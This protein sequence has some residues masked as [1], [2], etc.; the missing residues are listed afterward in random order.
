MLRYTVRRLL[1]TIPV[2]LLLV[3]L[4]FFMIRLAPGG[5][6][7]QERNV[8]PEV[9]RAL[10]SHY[11]LDKPLF[12]QYLDYLASLSKGDLGPSFRFANKTVNELIAD[13]FPVSFEL[14]CWALLVA[15]V[16]GLPV[17]ILAA[18]R[19]NTGLDY[20]PMSLAMVGICLPTFVMGPLLALVFGIHFDWL[21][22][23]GWFGWKDRILPALTLG[24]Y[25]AAYV[26]RL[27]RGGMLEV[28][29]QDFIRTAKAKGATGRRIVFKHALRGGM[30]PVIAFLG[31]AIAG[32]IAGSFVVETIFQVP[33]LGQ[34]FVKAATNRDY[35]MVMGTVLFFA[36]L[37]LILNLVVDILLT[38]LNPRLRFE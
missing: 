32:M 24:G 18:C 16:I 31:P 11:G 8:T 35:T 6:F 19:P 4:T 26:A 30:L 13:A 12:A 2:L 33:G 23:A 7:S 29:S 9:Q 28:L 22:P 1:E 5:P 37:I 38:W 15:L 25:Y 10:E 17:G 36:S 3:T 14:G 27:S 21:N 20:F 34:F